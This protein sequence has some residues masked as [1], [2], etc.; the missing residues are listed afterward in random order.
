MRHKLFIYIV[1]AIV[2]GITSCGQYEKILKSSDYQM[3]YDKALEYFDKGD[4][5]RS[6][7]ILE[8]IVNVY[9]GTTKADTVQYYRAKAYLNQKDYIMAGYYYDQLEASYPNSPFAEESGFMKAFCY[10]KQSPRPSLDQEYSY[11][12]IN[13]FTLFMISYPD[14]DRKDECLAYIDELREKLVEKS[15]M[16]S[17]LYFDLEQYKAAK[18]ALRNSL[19]EFPNTKYREQIMFMI[20]KANY[21]MAENSVKEKMDERYQ[22][23]VDEYYSF[24]GEFP[25][26][27]YADEANTIYKTAMDYL[28]QEIN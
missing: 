5:V 20:L 16:T 11:K 18:I 17:K 3:K 7:T 27:E 8:Q 23:T 19:N 1:I 15:Y 6:A 10:Y 13:A 26:G 28:G 14:S 22:S 25:D 4:Y 2:F 21:L 24:I 12:A 9:K